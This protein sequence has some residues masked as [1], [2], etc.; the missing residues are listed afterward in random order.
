MQ[1]EKLINKPYNTISQHQLLSPPATVKTLL[2]MVQSKMA[3]VV[4]VK[5][6]TTTNP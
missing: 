1:F 2:A 3:P 4:N 6:N 5:A